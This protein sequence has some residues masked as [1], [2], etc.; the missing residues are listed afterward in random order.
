MGNIGSD[1]QFSR[2]G[3][4]GR[5]VTKSIDFR[6]RRHTFTISSGWVE[7]GQIADSGL[8]GG[9]LLVPL[10]VGRVYSVPF[11]SD[12]S[13][14]PLYFQYSK[15]KPLKT[16]LDFEFVFGHASQRLGRDMCRRRSMSARTPPASKAKR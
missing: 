16:R 6:I 2:T 8:R 1:L 11:R 3:L 12:A 9:R 10:G 5:Y 15:S 14:W 13:I 7:G 4:L